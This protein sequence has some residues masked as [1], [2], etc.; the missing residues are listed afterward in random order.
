[1]EWQMN[2]AQTSVLKRS[3][4]FS[5]LAAIF[6]LS[7]CA[8][9]LGPTPEIEAPQTLA[10]E[11]SFADQHG[12]WPEDRWWQIYG[13][14]ELNRLEDEALQGSPDLKIAEA[15]LRE[16]EAASQQ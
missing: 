2:R 14:A 13:D 4:G 10:T 6:C 16:A 7:A 5:S 8:P 1:M 11:K 15:R 12:Q 3:I 9:D